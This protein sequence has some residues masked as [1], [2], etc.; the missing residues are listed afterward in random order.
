M[1]TNED[2]DHWRPSEQRRETIFYSI[3]CF[4]YTRIYGIQLPN[5]T[6][7]F[8]DF[9]LLFCGLGLEKHKFPQ[10]LRSL[11]PLFPFCLCVQDIASLIHTGYLDFLADGENKVNLL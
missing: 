6:E 9:F 5:D 7:K 8:F 3:S 1:K 4:D 11:I 10:V 2:E